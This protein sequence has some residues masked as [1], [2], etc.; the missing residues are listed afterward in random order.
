[1]S[2]IYRYSHTLVLS[3]I[4]TWTLISRFKQV[5]IC[6]IFFGAVPRTPKMSDQPVAVMFPEDKFVEACND[7][8]NPNLDGYEFFTESHGIKIYRRYIEES[9]LYEYKVFGTLED[10]D[11]EIC[12]QVYMDLEYR[13]KWDGY[14]YELKPVTEDGKSGV[15]WQVNFPFPMSNRDYVYM[16]QLKEFDIDGKHI[17][18]VLGKSEP[19]KCEPER[20]SV[21]RVDDF[22]QSMVLRSDGKNGTKAFM[23][24]Y[25]NPKGMIPTWLINWAAKTGVPKFLTDMQKACKGYP[26][27]LKTK[28]S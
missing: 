13:K 27:Y 25:D 9:G 18:A 20:K 2:S 24:Y 16:R 23:H 21:I 11:P 26:E 14:V 5:P 28:Q 6:R 15:Y 22:H 17:W 12:A 19:F 4:A 7:L 10:L 8:E 3:C 1:M